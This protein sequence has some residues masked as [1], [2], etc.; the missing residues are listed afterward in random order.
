VSALARKGSTKRPTTGVCR[1]ASTRARFIF[2][3]VAPD[4]VI[5]DFGLV[6]GGAAGFEPDRYD[7]QLGTPPQTLLLAS[8][9]GHSDNYPHVI[10]EILF[11]F[12]RT[13]RHTGC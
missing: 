11:M 2:E 7:L 13:G 6:G 5:G 4:E 9:E 3:G 12:P 8:S 10:E 1:T